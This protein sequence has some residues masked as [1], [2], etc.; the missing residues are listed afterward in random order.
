MDTSKI[1]LILCCFVLTVC[2][3]LSISTLVV[4]RNAIEEHG[5]VQ[6]NAQSMMESLDA[7]VNDLHELTTKD[8]S[9]SA[10]TDPDRNS[11]SLSFV[12]REINGKIG[13]YSSEGELLKLLDLP[14]NQLPK[15]DRE[16]LQ[17]GISVGSWRELIALIQDYTA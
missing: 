11:S 9:V 10:S 17:K 3:T 7:C 5:A 6:E 13:V 15:A 1:L 8:P 2:L 4:L 12:L 14:V 16:A